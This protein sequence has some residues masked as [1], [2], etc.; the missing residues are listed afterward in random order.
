MALAG[1]GDDGTESDAG[2]ALDAGGPD[3]GSRDASVRD[4]GGPDADGADAGAAC[5]AGPREGGSDPERGTTARGVAYEVEP[6]PGYAPGTEH[7]LLVVF[8]PA[9]TRDPLEVEAFTGLT[10]PAHARGWVVA[11]VD[12]VA[13]SDPAAVDDAGT[14]VGLVAGRWCIDAA[15]IYLSGYSDGGSVVSVLAVVGVD[16]PPAAVAPSAAGVTADIGRCASLTPH[17]AVRVAHGAADRLFP[18]PEYGRGASEYW[19]GCAGC[20]ATSTTEADGCLVYAGC[21]D[22]SEVRYCQTPGAHGVW[23]G[24]EDEIVEFLA[25]F[26]RSSR[27]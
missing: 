11:Y 25:R 17:P 6:P 22:G 23:P 1:C 9:G 19:A 27:P 13:P 15:R 18:P 20:D 10:A 3:G 7:P 2:P 24:D 26:A 5:P 4:A 14:V 12:H 21:P 8:A 16:P